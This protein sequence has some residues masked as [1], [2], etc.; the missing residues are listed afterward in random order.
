MFKAIAQLPRTLNHKNMRSTASCNRH[1]EMQVDKMC[2]LFHQHH[3]K[4]E[5]WH[6]CLAAQNRYGRNPNELS[7][8]TTIRFND[9]ICTCEDD[10]LFGNEKRSQLKGISSLVVTTNLVDLN[11][12]L[13]HSLYVG[14]ISSI[15]NAILSNFVEDCNKL[16]IF[17]PRKYC[18]L[19]YYCRQAI[20][21]PR[22][23]KRHKIDR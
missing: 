2:L 21:C 22:K 15:L 10:T 13:W 17:R 18:H 6:Y 5:C 3:L 12:R 23:E 14:S 8:A 20:F 4:P 16:M 11:Y 9:I 1:L 7:I 19:T